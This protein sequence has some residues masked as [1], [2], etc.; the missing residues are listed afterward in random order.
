MRH[1]GGFT[2]DE[3]KAR[4][5]L[6]KL[7]HRQQFVRGSLVTMTRT[8]G[9][10]GCKCGVSGEKHVSL[11]LSAPV[12]GSKGKPKR[13]MIYVPPEWE[14]RVEDWVNN[15]QQSE[16]LLDRIST[17]CLMRLLQ[18]KESSEKENSEPEAHK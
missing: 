12:P 16:G 13:K 5:R 9:K 8:C 3:R 1:R 7:L 6:V 14:A 17:H 15:Y 10:T 18:G 11:Y 2:V 4:S